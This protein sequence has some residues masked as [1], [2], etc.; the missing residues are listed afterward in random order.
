MNLTGYKLIGFSN[1]SRS[2]LQ[3]S[4]QE[5]YTSYLAKYVPNGVWSSRNFKCKVTGDKVIVLTYQ[6]WF[7]TF[8]FP[9]RNNQHNHKLAIPV[10]SLFLWQIYYEVH[11]TFYIRS[12]GTIWPFPPIINIHQTLSESS[13][14]K[15]VWWK[16]NILEPSM[17]FLFPVLFGW[18]LN[19]TATN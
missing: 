14:V 3:V 5:P 15:K 8:M 12:M 2:I 19:I 4:S 18:R 11:E 17:G 9:E 10:K 7:H 16:I 6:G 1:L 13:C